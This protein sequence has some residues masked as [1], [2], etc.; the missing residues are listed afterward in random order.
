[1]DSVDTVFLTVPG[2]SARTCADSEAI[3][4]RKTFWP[5][6]AILTE[7]ALLGRIVINAMCVNVNVCGIV[8]IEFSSDDALLLVDEPC[9]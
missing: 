9:S 2:F 8:V 5:D 4:V 3:E 1:M 7:R 6:V